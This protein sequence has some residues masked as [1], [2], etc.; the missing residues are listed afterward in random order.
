MGIVIHGKQFEEMYSRSHGETVYLVYPS[1]GCEPYAVIRGA[2]SLE[3]ALEAW[4]GNAWEVIHKG[5]GLH[6]MQIEKVNGEGNEISYLAPVGTA[7]RA[8][9]RAG[10][11]LREVHGFTD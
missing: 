5:Y 6:T 3:S 8:Q 2:D 10:R 4:G 9:E 7:A 1:K 11:I